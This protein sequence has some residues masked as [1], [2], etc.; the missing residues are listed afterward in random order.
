[1]WII[2]PFLVLMAVLTVLYLVISIWSRRM[3]R[4]KLIAQWEEAGGIGDRNAFLRSG[5]KEYDGSLRRKLILGVYVVP[6]VVIGVIVYVV[7][8]M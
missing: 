2:R 5:L 3:R 7:N 4:A 6:L 1:M 8:Y